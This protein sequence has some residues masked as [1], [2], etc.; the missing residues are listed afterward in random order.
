MSEAQRIW[1]AYEADRSRCVVCSGWFKTYVPKGGDGSLIVLRPHSREVQIGTFVRRV[2][3]EGG[4]K[5]G[6]RRL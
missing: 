1:D 6:R 3:C 5:E 4:G 2:R